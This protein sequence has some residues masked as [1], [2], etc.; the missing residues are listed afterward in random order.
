MKTQKQITINGEVFN[1]SKISKITDRTKGGD[2][3][4]ADGYIATAYKY[5]Y[6]NGV[7]LCEQ[8]D[9]DFFYIQC[10]DSSVFQTVRIVK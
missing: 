4:L 1:F 3:Y 8:E 10:V 6:G 2:I 9:A 7:Q 5:F